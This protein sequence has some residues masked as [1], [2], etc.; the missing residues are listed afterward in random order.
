[1][2]SSINSSVD[3]EKILKENEIVVVDFFASWCGP[4][5]MFYPIF[6]EVKN[7]VDSKLITVDIEEYGDIT[8]KYEVK[9][10][11]TVLVFKNGKELKRS[12]GFI[13]KDELLN[14]VNNV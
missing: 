6:Q 4:C 5:Q 7:E 10:I 14:L 2:K 1:M 8:S 11:P 13:S 3:F 12:L 9:S